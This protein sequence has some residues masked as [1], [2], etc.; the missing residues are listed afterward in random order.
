MT[1]KI[2]ELRQ[3]SPERYT[4]RFEDGTELRT[5]LSILAEFR[6]SVGR[7][8]DEERMEELRRNS[9]RS[10]TLEKAAQ[11]LSLRPLSGRELKDRLLSKGADPECADYCVRRLTEMGLINDAS[12]AASLA[13]HYASRGYGAGRIRAELSRR[14]IDRTLWDEASAQLPP[15]DSAIDRILRTKVKDPENREQIRKATAALYRRGFSWDEIRSALRR[16]EPETEDT[17]YD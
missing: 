4:V 12:Y 17:E 8:L 11:M 15:D 7:E 14:G 3:T 10:L 5:T 16:L 9:L 1:V 13:R 2:A 6:L